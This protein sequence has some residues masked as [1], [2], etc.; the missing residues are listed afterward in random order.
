MWALSDP[1]PVY[2][3]IKRLPARTEQYSTK[4]LVLECTTNSHKAKVQWLKDDKKIAVSTFPNSV[5]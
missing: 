5:S 4:E 3:F 1:D 2:K